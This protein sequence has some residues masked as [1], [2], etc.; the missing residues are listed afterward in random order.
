MKLGELLN[1]KQYAL[2]VLEMFLH[3]QC[4]LERTKFAYTQEEVWGSVKM[5]TEALEKQIPKKPVEDHTFDFCP[6]C[7]Y[8][9]D[10]LRNYCKHCGQA[11]DWGKEN[12]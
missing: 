1:P 7:S 8:S 4:D 12:D 10:Y 3:K 5:A 11:I 2:K 6:V 9:L